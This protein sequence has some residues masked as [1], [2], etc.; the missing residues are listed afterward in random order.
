MLVLEATWK[1]KTEHFEAI[2][3]AIQTAQFIRNYCLRYW[4]D[5]KATTRNDL[6]KYCK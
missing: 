2:D 6:Y 1:G 3:E 4:M 5:R